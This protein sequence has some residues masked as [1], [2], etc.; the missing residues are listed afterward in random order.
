MVRNFIFTG[1]YLDDD[2]NFFYQFTYYFYCMWHNLV[3]VLLDLSYSLPITY[4]EIYTLI[5]QLSFLQ[6][7]VVCWIL[8]DKKKN[9]FCSLDCCLVL[10]ALVPILSFRSPQCLIYRPKGNS[11][12]WWSILPTHLEWAPNKS[13]LLHNTVAHLWLQRKLSSC[14]DYLNSKYHRCAWHLNQGEIY[15]SHAEQYFF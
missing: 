14:H 6:Y 2:G 15:I 5:F 3:L 11:H 13:F 10:L 1:F 12:V 4:L 9:I 8:G 7:R